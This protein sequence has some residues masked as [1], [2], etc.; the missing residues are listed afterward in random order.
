MSI[1]TTITPANIAT[2][3]GVDA[4]AGESTTAEQWQMW[5]DDALMLIDIRATAQSKTPDQAKI[6]YVVR[7]A[8]VEHINHPDNSTQ[9]TV[10][11]DDGASTKIYKSGGGRVAITDEWWKM[12]GLGDIAGRAFQTDTMPEGAGARKYGRDYWWSSPTSM[13]QNL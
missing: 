5:I 9:V 13:E 7:Q 8:V 2:A 10:S 6:D 11:V 12:L 3:L 4:P 1:E